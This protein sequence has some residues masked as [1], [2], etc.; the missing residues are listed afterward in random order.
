MKRSDEMGDKDLRKTDLSL[1]QSANK[2]VDISKRKVGF[3]R[4]N[5]RRNQ[6]I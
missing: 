5:S 4:K 1:Y 3:K 2:D 6:I